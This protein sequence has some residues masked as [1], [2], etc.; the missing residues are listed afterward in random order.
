MRKLYVIWV[1]VSSNS[2]YLKSFY[3]CNTIS[4]KWEKKT[5]LKWARENAACTV[6]ES[7]VVVT[8]GFNEGRVPLAEA[9][10]W[11]GFQNKT[12][13]IMN[14]VYLKSVDHCNLKI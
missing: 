7:K 12:L 14:L 4:S 9:C 8:G 6:N 3:T 1:Y 5:S 10:E 2:T 11:K 13:W